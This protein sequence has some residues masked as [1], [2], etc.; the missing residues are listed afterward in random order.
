MIWFIRVVAALL[1][2]LQFWLGAPSDLF[3]GWSV[4]LLATAAFFGAVALVPSHVLTPR[5]GSPA[6]WLT[7]LL[8]AVVTV[9]IGIRSE[10]T[11]AVIFY[12]P[13]LVGLLLLAVTA[14]DEALEHDPDAGSEP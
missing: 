8:V 5:P 9:G 7:P 13:L 1:A 11:I 14:A 12:G 6:T 4:Y 2:A 3:P 10:S